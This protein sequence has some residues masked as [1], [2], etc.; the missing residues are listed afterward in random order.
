MVAIRS[1]G[2]ASDTII[3]Y[4]DHSS[5]FLCVVDENY[6]RIL[7]DIANDRFRVIGERIVKFR[8]ALK[9]V[10]DD[11]KQGKSDHDD[12]EDPTLRK[13]RKRAEGLRRQMVERS[14]KSTQSVKPDTVSTEIN[15]DVLLHR[16]LEVLE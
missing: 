5:E 11:S 10:Y 15:E 1:T 16:G 8:S 9:N 7:V 12:W 4:E 13:E 3:G 6:L 2:L 14:N